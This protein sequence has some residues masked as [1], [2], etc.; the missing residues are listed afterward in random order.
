VILYSYYRS[1]ASYRVRIALNLKGLEYEYR[2]VHL[3]NE[4]G[5]QNKSEYLELNPSREV[6]TLVHEGHVIGQSMA[7]IDYLDSIK[8]EPRLFPTQPYQRALVVQACEIVNSGIQPIVNLRVLNELASSFGADQTKKN[9]WC[10][11]WLTRGMEV[12]EQFLKP[13]A[14]YFAFGDQPSAA[15][16]FLVPHFFGGTRFGVSVDP[17]PTLKKI[18]SSCAQ[19]EAFRKAA[20]DLQ[21]D[22]PQPG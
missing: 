10:A 21:P 17:Y 8:R 18:S 11:H 6:P 1:S 13:H 7:I 5:E 12:L 14:G 2:P 9:E 15:D 3:L 16:C 19:L 20:P 4:G 22:T